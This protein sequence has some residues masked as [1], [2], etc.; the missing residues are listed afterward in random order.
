MVCFPV[1]VLV[2]QVGRVLAVVVEILGVV[3]CMRDFL[4]WHAMAHGR[5]DGCGGG[6]ICFTTM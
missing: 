1:I 2:E 5:C 3:A 4:G 6:V